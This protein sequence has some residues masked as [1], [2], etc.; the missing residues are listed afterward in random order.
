MSDALDHSYE[1]CK[2][3][4][5]SPRRDAIFSKLKE[6]M[7]PGVPGLRSFCPT[8]WTVRGSSLESI[9]LNYE[10]LQATWDEAITIVCETEVK[11]RING[12]AAIM[13]TFNFLFGLMLAERILKHTDNLSCTLQAPSLSAVEARSLSKLCVMV[14]QDLRTDSNFDLFWDLVL[15]TQKSL[16]VSD[17]V[18]PR[19]R[20]RPPR[21]EEGT[22]QPYFSLSPKE[23][24]KQIYFESLDAAIQAITDRCDQGDYDVYAKSEQVLILAATKQKYSDEL[25]AVTTF[26]KDDICET[27]LKTQLEVLGHMN[28]NKT[29]DKL[30]FI[31]IVA[32]FKSQSSAQ[33]E[34]ISQVVRL[35]KFVLL[36]PATNAVSERSASALR[37][38]K[39]YLRTSMGQARLNHLMLLYIHSHLT[40]TV[41]HPAILN[42]FVRGKEGRLSHFGKF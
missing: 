16:G 37:K 2:L 5:Y 34:Y 21:Y 26:F 42:D 39:N 27:Q 17:P 32:H 28:I 4:K 40:D 10:T 41:S 35:V 23:Y 11:A 9:R 22:A 20:K 38:I 1:I 31:D 19:Q 6:A 24:F 14:L 3:L 25:E 13:Q 7:S 36:M 29:G 30:T 8:R 15:S 33:L 18:L 12:V